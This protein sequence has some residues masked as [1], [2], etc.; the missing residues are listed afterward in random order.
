[1]RALALMLIFATASFGQ[2]SQ[3]SPQASKTFTIGRPI[4]GNLQPKDG[5]LDDAEL[6]A[7]LKRIADRVVTAGGRTPSEIRIYRS[8]KEDAHATPGAPRGTFYINAALLER[9]DNEAEL[10]GLMAYELAL[11]G[12]LGSHQRIA[13]ATI[14]IDNLK[15]A[16]YDP[17]EMLSL[18]SILSYE[19]PTWPGALNSDDLV[20]FRVKLEAE[21]APVADYLV[22][23][24]EFRTQHARLVALLGHRNVL[25]HNKQAPKL[26]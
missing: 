26:R 22:D 3:G 20:K 16:G 13:A 2:P 24:S 6:S 23:T 11:G 4:V 17:T 14:A 5:T 9:I 19:H 8:S 25:D 10:A 7:Y 1:M 12:E 15:F 18:L 21:A